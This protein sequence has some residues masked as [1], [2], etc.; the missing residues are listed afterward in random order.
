MKTKRIILAAMAIIVILAV[1]TTAVIAQRSDKPP[2][3][4]EVVDLREIQEEAIRNLFDSTGKRIDP[5]KQLA[6]IARDHEGGFGGYYFHETDKSI[7]YV[8][9]LDITKTAAAEAAFRA[10]HGDDDDITQIIPV[11]GDYSLDQLVEWY[12][13]LIRAFPASDIR[14]STSS[15]SERENRIHIGLWDGDQIDDALRVMGKLGIPQGAVIL[16]ED[17]IR[18]AADK[19]SVTAKWRPLVGGIKHQKSWNGITCTIGFVTER[20]DVEGMVVASHCTN[21]DGDVGGID[22]ADVHQPND[23]LVGGNIVA[24]ETIDPELTDFNYAACPD[25]YECRH[26]DAA[27][28]DIESDESLDLGEIAKP[29]GIGETDVDPAGA[30]FDITSD[31]GGFSARDE[32]YYIGRVGGWYTAE[33]LD[34]CAKAYVGDNVGILCVGK[35]RVTGS[36]PDPSNGDSGAPVVKLDTGNDVELLGTMFGISTAHPDVFFFSKIGNI[37]MELG[38]SSTWDSCVSNC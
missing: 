38:S 35:A 13:I 21:S 18:G 23:P 8:Y 22:N 27:F 10:A 11:Q 5:N 9:K 15:V 25:G 26:S 34:T 12:H 28:A 31:T 24:R 4:S 36:S 14:M 2:P 29:E 6:K 37:Y 3:D 1:G 16:E 33:V 19:D 7:V 30:T 17:Q 20:D 32:I